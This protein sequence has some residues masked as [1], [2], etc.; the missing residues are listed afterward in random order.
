MFQEF[1]MFSVYRMNSVKVWGEYIAGTE[2]DDHNNSEW[3]NSLRITL[4]TLHHDKRNALTVMINRYYYLE[5]QSKLRH[6]C[7]LYLRQMS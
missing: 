6:K 4:L 7:V 5:K 2:M 3:L 1:L